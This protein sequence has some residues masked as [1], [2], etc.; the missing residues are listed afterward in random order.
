MRS[1]I[2][3]SR[4]RPRLSVF[5]AGGYKEPGPVGFRAVNDGPTQESRRLDLGESPEGSKIGRVA[6]EGNPLHSVTL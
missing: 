6:G 4:R 3:L 1:P 5:C 2:G